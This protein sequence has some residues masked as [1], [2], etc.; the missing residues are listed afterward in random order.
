M[1][2]VI[3]LV[4]IGLLALVPALIIGWLVSFI[5]SELGSITFLVAFTWEFIEL[6]SKRKNKW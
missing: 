4:L 3:Y 6:I 2:N 5:D 1:R